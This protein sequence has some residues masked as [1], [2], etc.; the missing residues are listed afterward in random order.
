MFTGIFFILIFAV[1]TSTLPIASAVD[2]ESEENVQEQA[3]LTHEN[4]V[5][6]TDQFMETLVQQADDQNKVTD[7]YSKAALLNAFD[8]IATKETAAEYVDYYY[9]EEA[10]GLYIIPTE[11]PPWFVKEN[12]YDIVQLDKDKVKVEQENESAMFGRYSITIEFTLDK[13]QEWKISKIT[14]A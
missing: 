7:Y 8:T 12:D 4:I 1:Q 9:Y 2:I 6:L 13:T 11:T 3:A 10:G 5:K 14:H